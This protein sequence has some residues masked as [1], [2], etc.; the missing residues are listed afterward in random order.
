MSQKK[1]TIPTDIEGVMADLNGIGAI[2]TA[3]EWHRAAVVASFVRPGTGNGRPRQ[4]G[5]PL[6]TQEVYSI[7]GFARLGIIGL[8]DPNTVRQYVKAWTETAGLEPPAPGEEITLPDIEWPPSESAKTSTNTPEKVL[9]SIAKDPEKTAE[10]MDRLAAAQ[11]KAAAKVAAK[12]IKTDEGRKAVAKEMVKDPEA[13]AE[14]IKAE[15]EHYA[16]DDEA[17]KIRASAARV[18]ATEAAKEAADAEALATSGEL[19]VAALTPLMIAVQS[20]KQFLD[21]A[22]SVD[23]RADE[24]TQTLLRKYA[25]R[26]RDY[27]VVLEQIANGSVSATISDED[28][29]AL[30][31]A[32]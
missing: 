22:E 30:L 29:E 16:E 1:I 10:A 7:E 25:E 26:Y 18:K 3:K 14:F 28:L 19:T 15:N 8:K 6:E 32:S 20:T 9:A 5:N 27:A 17:R 12:A 24:D 21:T 4:D 31:G 2:I 11:P 23:Y 13:T